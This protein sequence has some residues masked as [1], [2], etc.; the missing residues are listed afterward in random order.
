MFNAGYTSCKSAEG[1]LLGFGCKNL[2]EIHEGHLT[3]CRNQ[4]FEE[5]NHQGKIER[6][7]VLELTEAFADRAKRER[8]RLKVRTLRCAY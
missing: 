6:D 3:I 1:V 7:E 4:K 8:E 2:L 5:K